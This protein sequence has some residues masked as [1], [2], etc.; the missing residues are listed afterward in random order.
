MMAKQ[1]QDAITQSWKFTCPLSYVL[2]DGKQ[3]ANGEVDLVVKCEVGK[4]PA[5]ASRHSQQ[6]TPNR[7]SLMVYVANEADPKV[8]GSLTCL[9]YICLAVESC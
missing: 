9:L 4:S 8:M 2:V 3:I 5:F 1:A 6:P 7:H